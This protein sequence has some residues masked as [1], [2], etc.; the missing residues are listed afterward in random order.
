VTPNPLVEQKVGALTWCSLKSAFGCAWSGHEFVRN[1]LLAW[2]DYFPTPEPTAEQER[3]RET[4][5]ARQANKLIT[6]N[7]RR[8]RVPGSGT[9][10]L[11]TLIFMS[12]RP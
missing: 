9:L 7:A 12:S 8:P 10:T 3:D 1:Q 6:A 4:R 5:R 11:A 2:P